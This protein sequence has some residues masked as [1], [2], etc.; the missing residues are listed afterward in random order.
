MT[1]CQNT[2]RAASQDGNIKKDHLINTIRDMSTKLGYETSIGKWIY[3]RL[4]S[5]RRL[6]NE[7]IG[8]HRLECYLETGSRPN[9]LLPVSTLTIGGNVIVVDVSPC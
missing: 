9:N 7:T 2:L 4:A 6:A 1:Q 8:F 5:I 3:A